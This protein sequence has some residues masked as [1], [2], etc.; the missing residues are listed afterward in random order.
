MRK[1]PYGYWKKT[2]N[3]LQELRDYLASEDCL[4]KSVMPTRTQLTQAGRHDL[5]GAISRAGWSVVAEAANLPLSSI[6]RPRSLNLVFATRLHLATGRMRP[7]MYW[8]N[9]NHVHGELL[10]TM[11]ELNMSYLPSARCLIHIGRSDLVRAIRIHGGWRA[12]AA[13]MDVKC[14]SDKPL[15]KRDH[16]LSISLREYVAEELERV[17]RS[18]GRLCHGEPTANEPHR[19]IERGI[20]HDIQVRFGDLKRVKKYVNSPDA[21]LYSSENFQEL[22]DIIR[23]HVLE[24]V[25]LA[26]NRKPERD[27]G[28]MPGKS[29]L[30]ALG[31]NDLAGL[32]DRLGRNQV[33]RFCGLRTRRFS[34]RRKV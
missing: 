34:R 28:M 30:T 17:T 20:L 18:A 6:A 9:F 19:T 10:Q 13:R 24:C 11:R 32:V 26:C 33:A 8:R 25:R 4:D 16:T 5:A 22:K 31:R 3:I 21:S 7:Y 29:E 14:A 12:V 23:S 27:P 2:S 1:K 15:T